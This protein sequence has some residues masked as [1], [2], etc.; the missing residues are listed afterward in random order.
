MVVDERARL[1]AYYQSRRDPCIVGRYSYFHAGHLFRVQ[2]RE[3]DLLAAFARH[4]FTNLWPRKI[5]DVGC[6]D[7]AHLRRLI[8]Y[9]ADPSRLT[10]VD[11]LPERIASAQL[12]DPCIDVRVADASALPFPDHAFHIV[13]Q[14]TVFSLIFD[15]A[16]LRRVAD[17]ISRVL[18]PGGVVISYDFCVARDR[19][20]TRP[21]KRGELATLF[22]GFEID[23]RR[24]TLA[25]PIAR[26]L[27]GRC[28][29]ACELLEL[30]PLLRSHELVV[31][32]KP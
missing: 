29:V 17:E 15:K 16:K 23:A 3:R 28:W 26:A 8:D 4:G 7:G 10:G 25:P 31:L 14:M 2:R 11:I 1:A 6:G 32:R 24:V 21:I 30:V 18:R 13:F 12:I 27:A 5:L 22:P 9:G 20:H 19:R